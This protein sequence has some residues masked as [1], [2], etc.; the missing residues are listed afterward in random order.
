MQTLISS[1]CNSSLR[2]S[3]LCKIVVLQ[4][5]QQETLQEEEEGPCSSKSHLPLILSYS[6]GLH[7][8]QLNLCSMLLIF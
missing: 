2:M 8:A 5:K 6:A 3:K 1:L 4:V 7:M